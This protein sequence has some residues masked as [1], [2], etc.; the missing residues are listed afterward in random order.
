MMSR[1]FDID[2]RV[3]CRLVMSRVE[4]SAAR[5]AVTE[6]L[7]RG[8]VLSDEEELRYARALGAAIK[9]FREDSDLL[10]LHFA[11]A[12]RI[13]QPQL[14]AL[15][16]P[17]A[18][19][20]RGRPTRAPSPIEVF[21]LELLVRQTIRPNLAFGA[22][23]R[24]TNGPF[25]PLVVSEQGLD[26]A[27]LSAPDITEDGR[28]ALLTMAKLYRRQHEEKLAERAASPREAPRRK[29]LDSG[30]DEAPQSRS[31]RR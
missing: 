11:R 19:L 13:S 15:E 16:N 25:G 18:S 1:M 7:D 22:I 12:L 10:Q 3:P 27:I 4:L 6:R 8:P 14:S 17:D 28:Q 9:S 26:A 2:N 29:H 20:S 31:R 30:D 24:R 21:Q 5:A 23:L